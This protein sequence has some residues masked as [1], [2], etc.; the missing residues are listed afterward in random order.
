MKK[1]ILLNV[2][3]TLSTVFSE[4]FFG[5]SVTYLLIVVA[6]VFYIN[7]YCLLIQ[8]ALNECVK[9]QQFSKLM[10]IGFEFCKMQSQ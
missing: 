10:V 6:L 1:T 8:K 3:T 2:T 4:Y 9:E 7:I 5:I